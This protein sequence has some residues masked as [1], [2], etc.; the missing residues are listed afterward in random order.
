MGQGINSICVSWEQQHLAGPL[1]RLG[2]E[3]CAQRT[4]P[5]QLSRRHFLPCPPAAPRMC[6]AQYTHMC[7][8]WDTHANSGHSFVQHTCG[9]KAAGLW[10]RENAGLLVGT[11]VPLLPALILRGMGT[12][13]PWNQT[14]WV[15]ILTYPP[16]TNVISECR[17]FASVTWGNSFHFLVFMKVHQILTSPLIPFY[18]GRK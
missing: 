15:Q 18:E 17:M 11:D 6:L 16:P 4:A 5:A 1:C 13:W 10:V 8:L 2:C 12:H 9:F 14:A 7:S 3:V